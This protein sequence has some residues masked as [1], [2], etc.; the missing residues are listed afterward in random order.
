[1]KKYEWFTKAGE[2]FNRQKGHAKVGFILWEV[3]CTEYH[4][5]LECWN[6]KF[7]DGTVKP[8]IWQI[9]SDT[10]GGGFTLW[11]TWDSVQIPS[12]IKEEYPDAFWPQLSLIPKEK[13]NGNN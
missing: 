12:K 13:E 9:Y 6:M 11:T 10:S 3:F 8:C 7:A 2:N 5:K 4:F 1:M